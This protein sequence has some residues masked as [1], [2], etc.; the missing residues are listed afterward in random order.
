MKLPALILGLVLFQGTGGIVPH[1][2][3]LRTPP[4]R[5]FVAPEPTQLKL[6]SGGQLL[7]I[8]NKELPLVDGV[9]IFR[10]GVPQESPAQ[11][12]ITELLAEVLREGGS[13]RT[14]GS[15]LDDWLDTHAASIDV[16]STSDSLR[17][18]FSCVKD[19]LGTVLVFI[20]EMILLP[21]Y[22]EEE[23]EF[24]RRRMLSRLAR[25]AQDPALLADRWITR[26][27]LGESFQSLHIP[28][29][30]TV[31]SI[32]REDLLA[33][34]SQLLGTDRLLVGATGAVNPNSLAA[35]LDSLLSTVPNV[36]PPPPA[37]TDVFRVP[38]RRTIYLLDRPELARAEVR[39]AAPG[40]RR[41]DADY[42]PL[43]LWS[44]A[45]GYG[46]TANR[47]MVRLRTE[48]GLAFEGSLYYQPE[49]ERA[50]RLFGACTTRTDGVIPVLS[51]C[52]ELLQGAKDPL[53][54]EEL[55]AVRQRMLNAEVFRI[56]SS[57]EVLERAL[58]LQFHGYP[59]D[60]WTRR[61]ERLRQLTADQVAEAVRRHLDASRLTVVVVG[62]A[63][64]LE[65]ELAA[66]GTVVRLED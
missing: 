25:D 32:R 18:E 12:G 43:S 42:V 41:L 11:A 36:G 56:D 57:Q 7:V 17:I 13:A 62:S 49:W 58:Q 34:H 29:E 15:D 45:T 61:D 1:P 6:E 24:S 35:R 39:V 2:R 63:A 65:E 20:G 59:A 40:T 4:L 64:D 44:Y 55:E 27:T 16:H 26:V 50:G 14:S 60:F 3:E 21:A 23:L 9:L 5:P 52:I 37:P 33:L 31:A 53:P 51:S 30:E 46:G 28:T 54:T 22:P 47:L 38:G 10:G 8:E 66:L 48:L 19:D